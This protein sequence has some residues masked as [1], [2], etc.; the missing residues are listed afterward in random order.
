M[1]PPELTA[2]ERRFQ[3]VLRI[4]I[5]FFLGQA[6]LYP[7]L[8]LFGSAEFPFVAN[9]FAKDGLFCALC[10]LAA[11]DVRQNGWATQL[12][13]GGHALI[14][15]ALLL[16]L[17][18]G[19]HDSVAQTF[20]EPVGTNLSPTLQLL[21]WAAAAS[22]V[23]ILLAVLYHSAARA[24]YSLKYLWPHQH[25]TAM[26]MAEVLVI[27]PDEALTPEQVAAGI[28]DYLYSFTA[29]DKWKAKL[30][31]SALTVYPLT[32]LRPPFAM[33]APDP[34]LAFIERCFITDV[35]ER[36]LP[37]RLRKL[38][39]SMLFGVHNLAV[40]G[41]YGDPRSAGST[42]YVPFSQ[43]KRYARV[44]QR[45]GKLATL[46]VTEPNE[47]DAERINA[48]V[49]II[50]SGAAG[51]LLAHRLAKR[52]RQV[53]VLEGGKYVNPRDFSED[54]RRQF[55]LLYADG[56]MQ[57]SKDA[58][59]QVLQGKCVGGSTVVNNAVCYDIP[60]RTLQRWN[61]PDGLDAGI[62]EK[63]FMK[64]FGDLRKWLPVVSQKGS[65]YLEKG[66]TKMAEGIEALGLDGV[67]GVVDAN[68]KDCLGSGYCNIGCQ[69]GKKLSALDN[70]LPR[71]QREFGDAVRIFSECTA[72]WIEVRD[73][74]AT[75]VRCRLADGR[76]LRVM[77]NTVVVSAGVLASSL[78]LQR[79]GLGGRRAG[80][81]L[82]FNV[83][84]PLTADFDEELNSF[85][86]L[87]ITH[88]YRPP[89]EEQLILESWFNPV[90]T[91]ALLMPGWFRDHYEN[92]RRYTHLSCIGVVVGSERNGR[93]RLGPFGSGMRLDYEPT[94]ADLRLMIKGTKLAARI[95]FASGAKRVM[96][97]TFRSLSYTSLRQV[98]G[99]DE[100][101][102][103]N[104]DI[105]LH[106][107]HPQG[108]NAVSRDPAKGVVDERFRVHGTEN[109]YVCDAS[110]FP[111]SVTVNPQLTVMALAD[112]A[113]PGI[114]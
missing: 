89:D 111:S 46:N 5:F 16:M 101:V 10:F 93:V 59:F 99:L 69:Y 2:Q 23:A 54:E 79:S 77:A 114:E 66:G 49:A 21:I 22:F 6:L 58:R 53:V 34:R 60:E 31:L 74:R 55:S 81:G 94:E 36:R 14:V 33:M 72:E 82:A 65:R 100:I 43:R 76:R 44:M 11:G 17:A 4:F 28:D 47:L 86:G 15:S 42:G 25:R 38:L 110:V 105:G 68:I 75:S 12:V 95:H 98:D 56:G 1:Q 78:L 96:P 3:L 8:G 108:G 63:K 91:Q 104:T 73:S 113:A 20:G 87:Q 70:I 106:T 85:D 39:Q 29:H 92:M 18:F 37:D 112:Y 64:S 67:D 7:A 50:G 32:R 27:G 97:M 13:I 103:D 83:G 9:S 48:D 62:D 52:G 71:A 26:A 109:V 41:Y 90:G 40:I 61:D 35:V 88:G 84:A 51:S 45:V 19:N 24:R 80:T 57:M 107:S 102:R 30:A